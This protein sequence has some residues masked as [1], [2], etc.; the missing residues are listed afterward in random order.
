MKNNRGRFG[1]FPQKACRSRQ[2]TSIK[3]K[4]A[5]PLVLALEKALSATHGLEARDA[6]SK[7]S[8]GLMLTCPKCGDYNDQARDAALMG[9]EG[10][11]AEQAGS[12]EAGGPMVSA[13]LKGRCPGCGS[14]EVLASFDPT[15]IGFG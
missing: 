9:G 8:D 5:Y 6:F 3:L 7:A 13:L 1:D 10:G 2:E 15:K 11:F 12:V 14:E 4:E